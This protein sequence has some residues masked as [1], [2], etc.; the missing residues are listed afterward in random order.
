M[1]PAGFAK[2]A[3]VAL[4][5]LAVSISAGSGGR[6]Q[7]VPH[8]PRCRGR[9][10]EA[11]RDAHGA[12]EDGVL[13][14]LMDHAPLIA[15]AL[16]FPSDSIG[17]GEPHELALAIDVKVGDRVELRA[18]EVAGDVRARLALVAPGDK[19]RRAENLRGSRD[20]PAVGI[21][22]R[23]SRL[24]S[25]GCQV[26]PRTAGPESRTVASW[27][28]SYCTRRFAITTDPSHRGSSPKG[29]EGR[30][31]ACPMR[32]PLPLFSDQGINCM[33]W[34]DRRDTTRMVSDDCLSRAECE[35]ARR[36]VRTIDKSKPN[37][38]YTDS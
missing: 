15:I 13:P 17:E 26:V 25:R 16:R 14:R 19:E 21:V 27:Q 4:R 22:R 2:A 37:E 18:Q 28:E 34:S 20:A 23:E 33:H 10:R 32:N 31:W 36:S 7:H 12:E 11:R 8:R 30:G 24:R 1:S 9:I 38:P 5:S 3:S 6:R 29:T 35:D